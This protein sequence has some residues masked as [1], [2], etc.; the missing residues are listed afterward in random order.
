M[1]IDYTISKEQS[2]RI[3]IMKFLLAIFVV[4]IHC[5]GGAA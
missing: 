2:D 5:V 4:Y 1:M 3:N